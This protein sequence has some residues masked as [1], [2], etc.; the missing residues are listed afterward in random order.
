M[1]IAAA[2]NAVFEAMAEEYNRL[3]S[4]LV[5]GSGDAYIPGV[6]VGDLTGVSEV[7][8]VVMARGYGIVRT[9][10]GD[11][12]VPVQGKTTI[13][14]GDVLGWAAIPYRGSYQ[15][16]LTLLQWRELAVSPVR[17]RV[18]FASSNGLVAPIFVLVSPRLPFPAVLLKIG[19]TSNKEQ[20]VIIR[21]RGTKGNYEQVLFE[22][23]FKISAGKSETLYNIFGFPV[24]QQFVLELQPSDNTETVLDYLEALP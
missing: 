11:F 13:A 23:S 16:V 8:S 19:L 5:S 12:R 3:G 20:T 17:D 21:G 18:R 6:R 2:D 9:P 4:N 10:V 1:Q 22:D 7:G 15:Y 14:K 24:V